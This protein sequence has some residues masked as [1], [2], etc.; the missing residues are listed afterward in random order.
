MVQLSLD[1]EPP[2]ARRPRLIDAVKDVLLIHEWV[3]PYFVQ[4]EIERKTGE[5]YCDS[6]M[7]ARIRDLRKARYGGYIVERRRKEGTDSFEYRIT[8][9]KQWELHT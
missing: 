2:R 6:T 9:K 1:L 8:G 5:F 3:T 4:R 7:S